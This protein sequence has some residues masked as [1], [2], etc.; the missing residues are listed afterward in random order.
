MNILKLKSIFLVLGIIFS[1]QFI[2]GQTVYSSAFGGFGPSDIIIIGDY[3]YAGEISGESIARID[4][5][6][7]SPT[8]EQVAD[9][10]PTGFGVWKLGYDPSTN[11]LYGGG[12]TETRIIDLDDAIPATSNA[13]SNTGIANGL[14]IHDNILFK[15]TNDDIYSIDLSVGPGSYS[16]FYAEPFGDPG[17]F[18]VVG[19]DLYYCARTS[20]TGLRSNVYK[21]D[22]TASTPFRTLVTT[23][24]PSAIQSMH[25]AGDYLY[26]GTEIGSSGNEVLYKIDLTNSSLPIPLVTVLPDLPAA[27][28]GI[29]NQGNT[30][31]LSLGDQLIYTFEDEI[32]NTVESE[33]NE[34]VIYPNPTT[35]HLFIGAKS[36]EPLAYKIVSM[37]GVEVLLGTLNSLKTI[38]VS[39][40]S[41]GIYFIELTS[42]EVFKRMRF[43]KQ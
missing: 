6:S 7:S 11:I 22:L 39:S 20:A 38:D 12:F 1:S 13:F 4:L 28:L 24:P 43:I 21:I 32:L 37:N 26:I 31:Y 30:F 17:N 33:I 2:V 27:P 18:V 29:A 35:Q 5:S 8:R 41:A 34:I 19:D 10:W 40:L 16:V 25:Y 14:A 15:G 23:V 36:S 9:G 3:L 42:H